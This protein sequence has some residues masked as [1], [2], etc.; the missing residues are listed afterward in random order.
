MG[1]DVHQVYGATEYSG[2]ISF[3]SPDMGVEKVHSM[4]KPVFHGKIKIIGPESGKEVEPD[5]I[6]EICIL[7]PQ[8]FKGYWE[9][10]VASRNALVNG[11]YRSGDLGKKDAQG[12]VYVVDRL[13]DMIISGGENIYPVELE[14]VIANHPGIA[15]VAVV[16]KPHEKWGEIPVAFVVK[17]PGT[18]I[19]EQDIV[20]LCRQNLAGFK[21]VKEIHF[22][23]EVPRNTLGKVLKRS[24]KGQTA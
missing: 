19:T 1:I 5:G 9:N 4:G 14:S 12:F 20:Q 16:G 11:Y 21:C 13:K 7:G 3:W 22:I 18:T 6:G 10:P 23:D 8:V 2:A 15:D 17:K 24:L